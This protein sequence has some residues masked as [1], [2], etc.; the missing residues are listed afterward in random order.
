MPRD[1]ATD[2]DLARQLRHPGA[3]RGGGATREVCAGRLQPI[4]LALQIRQA[5]TLDGGR[6]RGERLVDGTVE[7]GD[8][9]SR[10]SEGAGMRFQAVPGQR[11][12][13]QEDALRIA[14]KVQ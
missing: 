8:L 7:R 4:Q 2:L 10:G 6:D 13:R 3:V 12:E 1:V 14:R 5:I 9:P 11:E